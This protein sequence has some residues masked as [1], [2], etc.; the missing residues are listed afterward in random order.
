M[1]GPDLLADLKTV[2]VVGGVYLA[3]LVAVTWN[4]AREWL[5]RSFAA[6]MPW[7]G[8]I[9]AAPNRSV[10]HKFTEVRSRS[11]EWFKPTSSGNRNTPPLR[12]HGINKATTTQ[13]FSSS[14]GAT[15]RSAD[16]MSI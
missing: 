13:L 10:R 7:N 14:S 1:A 5:L 16:E 15:I 6:A 3:V 9:Y 8:A 2:A 12:S 11:G 4:Y